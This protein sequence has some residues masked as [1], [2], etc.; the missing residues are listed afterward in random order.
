MSDVEHG[1]GSEA[2]D[3]RQIRDL[4]QDWVVWRD[5]GS[6]DAVRLVQGGAARAVRCGSV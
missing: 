5:A 4:L 3:R 2:A 1:P 6:W